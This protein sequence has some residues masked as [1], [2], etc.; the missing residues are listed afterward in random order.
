M[1]IECP[2]CGS[3]QA[4]FNGVA[5]ECPDCNYEWGSVI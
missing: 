4:Y 1:E 3:D 5:Y 2:K